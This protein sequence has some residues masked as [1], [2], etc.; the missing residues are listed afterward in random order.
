MG[1][2]WECLGRGTC[3]SG[4][5]VGLVRKK[6]NYDCFD[7]H[8]Y[9]KVDDVEVFLHD[10]CFN[11]PLRYIES[12]FE[13]EHLLSLDETELSCISFGKI[14]SEKKFLGRSR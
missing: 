8:R 1:P 6:R 10:V 3:A 12:Q 7:D 5:L 11:A 2:F 14:A 13:T 4:W 9:G